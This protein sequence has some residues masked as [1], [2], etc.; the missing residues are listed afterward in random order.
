MYEEFYGLKEK[1]F[2]M[3]PDPEYLFL[4]ERHKEALAHLIYG[5]EQRRG[6]IV[7]TGEVGTGKTTL[8]RALL[9]QFGEDTRI[10]LVLNPMMSEEELLSTILNEFYIH[11][12]GRSKK[13]LLD[14]LDSFLIEQHSQ[15]RNVVLVIDE[16][17]NLPDE[18]LE[19]IRI[20]SNLETEKVKLIQIVLLGQPELNDKLSSDHLRQ[21]EQ[22]ISVRYHLTP[23]TAEETE[24]YVLHRIEIAGGDR[25]IEFQT[26][27]LRLIHNYSQGIPRKINVLCDRVLLVGYSL[28]ESEI[29]EAIVR[30]A[31]Q[32]L[33][34]EN[35]RRKGA[36][37]PRVAGDNVTVKTERRWMAYLFQMFIVVAFLYLIGSNLWLL[38]LLRATDEGGGTKP[39]IFVKAAEEEPSARG[40]ENDE[41]G[42]V[43]TDS[44][45]PDD[46]GA[47]QEQITSAPFDDIPY[48][49]PD[50]ANLVDD[51]SMEDQADAVV[52]TDDELIVEQNTIAP[53]PATFTPTIVPATP[54]FTPTVVPPTNTPTNVP[55][56]PTF[57]HTETPVPEVSWGAFD[58]NEIL[59]TQDEALIPQAAWGTLTGLMGFDKAAVE[60]AFAQ[61]EEGQEIV[62][63]A[64]GYASVELVL[65]ATR[66]SAINLPC[67]FWITEEE[68]VV[69][70]GIEEENLLLGDPVNGLETS[71][72][73]ELA[74][75][76]TFSLS[77]LIPEDWI[78]KS[79]FLR[80][81]EASMDIFYMQQD[82]KEMGL[83]TVKSN[84]VYG[85]RTEAS[86]MK[87]QKMAGLAVDGIVG[88]E[89]YI[90]LK[91]WSAEE[92]PHLTEIPKTESEQ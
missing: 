82:L 45:D 67:L 78:L 79:N 92:I 22:R 44:A 64:D 7:V 53:V 43:Q 36:V 69:L 21:L 14:Q 24:Q 84:G 8:C 55:P 73:S 77:Y 25:S 63:S 51:G 87:F 5:I 10:A 50:P 30:Q 19:Q 37:H 1:P 20:I 52:F 35:R 83:F 90:A 3:T 61:G 75:G 57:T 60:E 76:R 9:S 91:S 72:W 17:Q 86:I 81:V 27:A 70:M 12:E 29:T 59:R 62:S 71:T 65:D 74:P 80:G 2:N 41:S 46:V 6:F 26:K 23:L 16:A 4:T 32:E 68:P 42:E 48:S 85:P 66:V 34:T 54:T 47:E 49:Q 18:T 89:T 33:R 28:G 58:E 39:K 38:N 88:N 40:D 13:E 15:G 31:Y 56:T 11:I